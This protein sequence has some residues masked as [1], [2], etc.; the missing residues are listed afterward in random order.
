MISS[1]L[2]L[3]TLFKLLN[4]NCRIVRKEE[5]LPSCWHDMSLKLTSNVLLKTNRFRLTLNEKPLK[6]LTIFA[7]PWV[8]VVAWFWSIAFDRYLSK[9]GLC[10]NYLMRITSPIRK[11]N[12]RVG[13]LINTSK[14]FFLIKPWK[15][16]LLI[17]K[18]G[19][20]QF[21]NAEDSWLKQDTDEIDNLE[22]F[23][24]CSY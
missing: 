14:K 11:P 24:C 4:I 18:E 8:M 21:L 15:Q 6:D 17:S 22:D 5:Q 9:P 13:Y 20:L 12:E 2:N 1:S 23:N 16:F 3:P 7:L 10:K 19:F